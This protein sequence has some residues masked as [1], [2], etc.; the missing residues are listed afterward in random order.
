MNSH[1]CER[2][3]NPI[4][5]GSITCER[6]S[7]PRM[8]SPR[9]PNDW[10]EANMIPCTTIPNDSAKGKTSAGPSTLQKEDLS[11]ALISRLFCFGFLFSAGH[12]GAL[13]SA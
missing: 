9:R 6:G 4:L 13:T 7:Q 10:I 5:P 8:K 2:Q 11:R 12:M 1:P 3:E